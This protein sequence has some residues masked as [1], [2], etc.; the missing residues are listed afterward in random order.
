MR[1]PSISIIV[2][3]FNQGT[4]I[5]RTI[6]SILKQDYLGHVQVIV[7]DGGSK[8][9]TVGV[10]KKYPQ[11]TWWSEPDRGFVDAVTKGLSVANGELIAI[12]SSDDFY[13]KG[14]FRRAAD[15]LRRN[16]EY[17]YVTGADVW[18][19]GDGRR[20]IFNR[21]QNR[22]INE[23]RA[24]V[25]GG[26]FVPQHSTFVRRTAIDRVG[27]LRNEADMCADVD[28]WY[29]ISFF[30]KGYVLP[31]HIGVYQVHEAQR[32]KSNA[33]EWLRA[34]KYMVESCNSNP[35]Y[36]SRFV[37]TG[38][39]K[40]ELFIRW[41]LFWLDAAGDSDDKKRREK[42]ISDV[43]AN[44]DRYSASLVHDVKKLREN[45][46]ESAGAGI[47]NAI[48]TLAEVSRKAD[49]E[50]LSRKC[51]QTFAQYAPAVVNPLQW[52]RR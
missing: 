22:Q 34:L 51:L 38:T 13:M 17:D 31:A 45:A 18:L 35:E 50:T 43:I 27:G 10:L 49:T 23:P 37:L 21:R 19:M 15:F 47:A 30:S 28:L 8:D 20:C 25:L 44:R 42:I 26:V 46:H 3:S 24:I 5:E 40:E 41:E 2:P 29:R 9:G 52:W 6:L 32:T 39:E 4:Y 1:W 14:A 33:R 36:A 7:A 16:S 12:Q 48:N 11:I